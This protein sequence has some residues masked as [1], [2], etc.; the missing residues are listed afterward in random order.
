MAEAITPREEGALTQYLG[1][2]RA[3]RPG[4]HRGREGQELWLETW[5]GPEEEDLL[6]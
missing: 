5:L 2:G 4:N 6:E 1:W 3:A